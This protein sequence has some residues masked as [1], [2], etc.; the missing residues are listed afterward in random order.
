[1]QLTLRFAVNKQNLNMR[2]TIFIFLL[3]FILQAK[4]KEKQLF[5]ATRVEDSPKIDGILTDPV[6]NKQAPNM[7]F[8]QFAPNNGAPSTFQT[9]VQIVYTDQAIY[10]AARL[11][12]PEPHLIQKEFG[13]RDDFNRNT[14]WFA[15]MI[16]PYQSGINAFTF[17]VSAAGV[18]GD[19]FVTVGDFDQSW[20]AVWNSAIK[21]D[22]QGWTVEM[23]IPYF[24]IRFP[25][26]KEQNWGLNFYRN[27]KRKQEESYWNHVDNGI[28]GVV[29]QQGTLQGISDIKPPFRLSLSPYVTGIFNHDGYSGK[30]EFSWAGGL[31]LKY[32]LNES[33]TLD[34][35]LIP[36]F[37]QVQS[38]NIVYNISPF[39]VQFNENRQFFTE[40]TDLFNKSGLF[41][42]RRVGQSFRSIDATLYN[43]NKEEVIETPTAANL[44]NA[45]KLSG[46]DKNGF[47]VGLFN[48]IS[49]ETHALIR[50]KETGEISRRRFDPLTNFNV[51]VI[52]QNL[53][54]NSNIN[55]TNTNVTRG[56][57]GKDANVS[58]LSLT[59][60]DKTNTYQLYTFGAYNII[61]NSRENKYRKE[62]GFKY[63]IDL[64]KISGKWQYGILQNVESDTYN[65]QDLGFLQAPNEIT[66]RAFIRYSILKPIGKINNSNTG[67][68]VSHQYL[69]NPRT[70]T[71][72]RV[73]VNHYTQLK[74]F[75]GVGANFGFN[76]SRDYDY[77]ESRTRGRYFRQPESFNFNFFVESDNRKALAGNAYT[78]RWRRPT[79]NQNFRWWGAYL[80]W[81]INNKVSTDLEVNY[82]AGDSRGFVN[83]QPSNLEYILFGL[84]TM[85]NTTNIYGFN[86]TFNRN[87]GLRLR[88]RHNWTTIRYENYFKLEANGDLSKFD[89]DDT[90]PETG[91]PKRFDTNFNAINLDLVYFWQI[92]PG[93]F[94]NFV[95]KDA[96]QSFTNNTDVPYFNNLGDAVREPHV[97]SVSLR[98]TYFLDYLTIKNRLKKG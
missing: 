78:G 6:W 88:I 68:N 50:N 75:W 87:M 15:F 20:D 65:P 98:I 80:R 73:N 21:I 61:F 28:D 29:N 5:Q 14:D 18:Q 59:L 41:Y 57:G 24:A 27:I 12:D 60:R 97:N 32:G 85:Q 91:K 66:H 35:T 64:A 23:M 69:Y 40:G 25:N 1:M 56:S 11:H 94:V 2:L 9:Q 8:I 71:S 47:G 44:V 92:A 70:Y 54:N 34:M 90:H 74:N 46:R 10:V 26:Q 55:F 43:N 36:D 3:P 82:E 13:Q 77:F 31:D 58:G 22:E 52:D 33:Y 83:N 42:S 72:F 84:R 81:R 96:I 79:W 93:S 95:W 76:P 67:I 89:F 16:D 51:F 49:Q 38:D 48:A 4:E 62:E 45:T 17:F 39:E 19:Y 7:S 30:G 37:S 86:I 63:V 53:K